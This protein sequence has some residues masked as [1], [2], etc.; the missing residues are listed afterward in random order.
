MIP[1]VAALGCCVRIA[2]LCK[3]LIR[4]NGDI[5]SI[6]QGVLHP[7]VVSKHHRTAAPYVD[8]SRKPHLPAEAVRCG[9][10]G[11]GRRRQRS[12]D[13]TVGTDDVLGR[14]VTGQAQQ[15]LAGRQPHPQQQLRL[16]RQRRRQRLT[17]VLHDE[18]R[19]NGETLHTSRFGIV[20]RD[21][22]HFTVFSAAWSYNC[23]LHGLGG[24]LV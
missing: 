14:V 18:T 22:C 20:R 9:R 11:A 3:Y 2:I 4:Y 8:C 13:V 12:P 15:R 21:V 6:P 5:T 17:Q 23:S 10:V 16:Q 19:R 7:C 1:F 24:S